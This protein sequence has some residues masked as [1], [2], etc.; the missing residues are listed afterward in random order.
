LASIGS[1]GWFSPRIGMMT[2]NSTASS[3]SG[4][5]LRLVS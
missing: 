4:R 5:T 1:S 2:T 3:L